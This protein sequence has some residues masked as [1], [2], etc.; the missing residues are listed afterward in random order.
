MPTEAIKAKIM[1]LTYDSEVNLFM[2][3]IMDLNLKRQ[4]VLAV[5]GTDWGIT[6]DVPP[7]I[8]KE[9]CSSMIGKEKNIFL[10]VDTT[11]MKQ[12]VR[13]GDKISEESMKKVNDNLNNYPIAEL[14]YKLSKELKKDEG[15]K[16]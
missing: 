5:R 10:E 7:D 12:E 14:N 16:D 2:M 8:V 3:T 13:D 9:F 15:K 11:T 6:P 4:T 1:D